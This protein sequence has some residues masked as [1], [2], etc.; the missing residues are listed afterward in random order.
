[1]ALNT[2][3]C[4]TFLSP[5][6]LFFAERFLFWQPYIVLAGIS[7]V[8][9]TGGLDWGSVVGGGRALGRS[10]MELGLGFWVGAIT[11]KLA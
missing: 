1:V 11:H 5:F 9:L 2:S 4:S 7:L 8:F 3:G 10:V 6:S